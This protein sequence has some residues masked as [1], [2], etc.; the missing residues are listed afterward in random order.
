MLQEVARLGTIRFAGNFTGF[1][2]AFTAYGS[3]RTQVGTCAPTSFERD[4]LGG[5]LVLS[6]RLASG[7]FDVGGSSR[8]AAGSGHSDIRVNAQARASP[9]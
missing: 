5:M 3:T 1:P 6:G 4:T 2:N 9:T 8:K 7:R